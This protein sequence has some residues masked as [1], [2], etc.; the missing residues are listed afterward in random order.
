M[1]RFRR[2]LDLCRRWE[3][4]RADMPNVVKDFSGMPIIIWR[5]FV[6]CPRLAIDCSEIARL[7]GS[8]NRLWLGTKACTLSMRE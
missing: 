1:A 5:V 6:G 2:S 3:R 4:P 7:P 8:K